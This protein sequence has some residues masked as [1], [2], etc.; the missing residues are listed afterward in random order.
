MVVMVSGLRHDAIL[1]EPVSL[2]LRLF[3]LT[4]SR[5]SP[6]S[7]YKRHLTRYGSELVVGTRFQVLFLPPGC[8]FT[9]PHELV[10]Y[11]S[12]EYL[13]LGM[14]LPDS[15]EFT[16]PLLRILPDKDYFKYEVTTLWLILPIFFYL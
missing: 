8:F 2:R 15:D 6:V 1:F 12:L 4:S 5:N 10:H 7:F 11:R 14:V 16:S 9:F 3:N 13:R